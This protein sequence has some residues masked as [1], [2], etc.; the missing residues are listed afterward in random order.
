MIY[1]CKEHVE[2][3]LDTIVDEYETAPVM[4]EL[5]EEEKLSTGCEYC[6]NKAAYLV[7]N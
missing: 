4:K 6:E 5:S 3:A 2:I 1:C 7:A